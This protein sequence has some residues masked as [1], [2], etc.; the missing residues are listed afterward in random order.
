MGLSQ[1]PMA[2][3]KEIHPKE[4]DVILPRLSAL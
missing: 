2:L 1:N 3:Q 4:V